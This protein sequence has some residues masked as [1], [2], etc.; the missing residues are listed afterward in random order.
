MLTI[1][2]VHSYFDEAHLE[3]VKAE[4]Q[5]MGA[6]EIKCIWSEVY[7]LW[8]AVEGCHRL[9]AAKALG[10]CPVVVDVSNDETVDIQSDDEIETRSIAEL[11]E[12]LQDSAPTSAVLDFEDE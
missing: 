5:A 2:L 10:L 4:M 7:G 9:R 12:E 1:A 3:T 11:M 6:P 8:L